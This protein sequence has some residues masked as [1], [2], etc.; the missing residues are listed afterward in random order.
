MIYT[1]KK[2]EEKEF[3]SVVEISGLSSEVTI[4]SLLDA[5]ENSQRLAKETDTQRQVTELFLKEAREKLPQLADV[6]P[7]HY[8]LATQYFMK[9]AENK[10]AENLIQS[11]QES[12][13]KYSTHLEAIEEATGIKCLPEVAP[14]QLVDLKDHNG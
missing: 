1:L 4:N 8:A 2:R 7:E 11:C 5:L 9:L 12:I 3:D 14:F 6:K 13:K 10:A